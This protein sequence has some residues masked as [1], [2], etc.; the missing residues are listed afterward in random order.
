MIPRPGLA[1]IVRR[2]EAELPL[3]TASAPL[4]RNLFTP[5][6]RALSGAEHGLYGHQE[7]IARQLF[8]QSCDEDVLL[9]V[10]LPMY[11]PDGRKP[12]TAAGGLVRLA[13]SAGATVDAG[14]LLD[15]GDGVLFAVLDGLTLP[16]SGQAS[17]WVLCTQPG[18]QGNS[19]AGTS[20]QLVNP[21][22]GIHGEA[23][24]LAD[25]LRGG[26]DLES[27]DALRQ[28]IVALRRNGGQ[29]GRSR[30]WVQ[31]ACEL[32]GVT[33]AW[34][35]PQLL[36][37]GSMVLYFMRDGDGDPFPDRQAELAMQA[38]LEAT[39]TPMGE[40]FAFSPRR[41]P[42]DVVLRLTP[43]TPATRRSVLAALQ[44]VLAAE[45]SP[46]LCDGA[47]TLLP[48]RGST[49][50]RSHLSEAISTAPGEWDHQLLEP[51][52]DVQC[53]VGELA[54]LGSVTWR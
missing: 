39:G 34:A 32:P 35:A 7:Q 20:L 48:V 43:D 14:A 9:N 47:D 28:R 45:A 33:R 44:H 2:N 12:P 30:D 46:V 27:L 41:R 18:L 22:P 51:A 31:W 19:A 50:L 13:G 40:I 37:A 3:A 8:P 52:Q 17:V 23:Q 42:V 38:H 21:L 25:G 53:A 10:F 54:V 5:L 36:G 29:V 1:E 11:L 49:L 26:N 16:D 4:R 24:V 6:A 15:R